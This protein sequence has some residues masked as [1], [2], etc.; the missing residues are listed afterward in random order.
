[1]SDK[2]ISALRDGT[3]FTKAL[4][5]RIP[6]EIFIFG[7]V[8]INARPEAYV[9]FS[10]DFNRFRTLPGYLAI[11]EFSS[12]P[13][14]SDLKGFELDID[15][16]KSLKNC[17]TGKCSVQM[18]TASMEQVQKSVDWSAADLR[19]RAN[20]ILQE[21]LHGRLSAYQRE[22]TRALGIYNDKKPPADAADRFKYLISYPGAWPQ[23]LPDFYG[24]LLGYPQGRPANVEDTFYWAKVKFGLKPTLRVVH[25]ATMRGDGHGDPAFVVAEKQLYANHYFR[26]ALDLS[27]CVPETADPN[28]PGFYLIRVMGS[29]QAGLTGIVGSIV[30]KIASIRSTS[31]LK[32]ALT[33]IKT[34][35]EQDTSRK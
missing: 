35:V 26:S 29:E 22:G 18:S 25:I 27:F 10:R 31:S 32:K 11:G 28:R 23:Q 30:R 16:I 15:E 14:L 20:R 1:M 8:Y 33:I 17:R 2:Q 6:D 7:A 34:T 9:K 12:P 5:T 24:Y 13:H 21:S 19:D 4:T 3:P